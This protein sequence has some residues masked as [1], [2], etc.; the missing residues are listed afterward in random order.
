MKKNI[1]KSCK[2]FANTIKQESILM[3]EK[4]S[5]GSEENCDI[6]GFVTLPMEQA[7]FG[8]SLNQL[9]AK[10]LFVRF[11]R[12][13]ILAETAQGVIDNQP[14]EMERQYEKMYADKT[15]ENEWSKLEDVKNE[16][17]ATIEKNALVPF[18]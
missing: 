6:L 5:P 4:T 11:E 14:E 13:R 1:K 9:M 17:S 15:I 12:T 10:L 16:I 3:S 2:N 7:M 8:F 18:S